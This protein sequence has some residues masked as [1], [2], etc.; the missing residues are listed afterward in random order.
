MTAP[1]ERVP[2]NSPEAIRMLKESID[3]AVKFAEYFMDRDDIFDYNQSFLECMERFIVLRYGR[4]T[5]K[6][7]SVALKILH[8]S[9]FAGTYRKRKKPSVMTLMVSNSLPQAKHILGIVM[10]W[11][12]QKAR[13]VPRGEADADR[14]VDTAV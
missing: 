3:S 4:Q 9:C 10:E 14:G 12:L 1:I 13:P 5:G 7:T 8:F 6:T 2:T 11:I